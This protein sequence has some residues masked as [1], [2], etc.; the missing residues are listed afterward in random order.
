LRD[1]RLL[2][3]QVLCVFGATTVVHA[4]EVS[5]VHNQHGGVQVSFDVRVAA[6]TSAALSEGQ[7]AA[8]EFTIND[9]NN[10]PLSGLYPAAW[11]HPSSVD[12]EGSDKVC[13]DKVKTFIGGTL[14]SRAELDL[15]VYYVLTMNQDST[16]SVVDP[17]FGFGGSKLLTML[18]LNGPGYD[19]VINQNQDRLIVSV[20]STNQLA[21]IDI[22][23]WRVSSSDDQLSLDNPRD[24]FIQPDQQYLWVLDDGG[25]AVLDL[26]TI[27]L[28]QRINTKSNASEMTFSDDGAIAY[29]VT[30]Q[31]IEV[32]DLSS[33]AITRSIKHQGG[34]VS[35][36]YSTRADEL[37]LRHHTSGDIWVLDD[38]SN[39][40]DAVIP[41]T[42]GS[43]SLRFSP[44]GRWGILLNTDEDNLSIIDVAKGR[45]VQSG[46]V[47]SR[48]E[49]IAFSDN[50]AYIRHAG[51][52][53]LYMIPLDDRDLGR[54]GADIP[55]VDTPGGDTP[56]GRTDFPSGG[57]GIVQAPGSNAVLVANYG[58]K[59]VYFYK[60]GMAAPMGQFNNYGKHPRSVMAIDHSL[61]E[62][63]QKGV[64]SSYAALPKS[65]RYEAVLF[66][67]SPRVVKCFAFTIG[68]DDGSSESA[69]TRLTIQ[70]V[71]T[72]ELKARV[73]NSMR[74][75]IDGPVTANTEF[76]VDMYLASGQWQDSLSV[77]LNQDK[78]LAFDFTPPRAGLYGIRLS[79]P[80]FSTSKE[81]SYDID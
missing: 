17:L 5:G 74:Y 8:F 47:A 64:Y 62:R 78:T 36:D 59:A 20:P 57:E 24:L 31:S 67:D 49:Y 81:F 69:F 27:R 60:E 26:E 25:A 16:I 23:G 51:S 80:A 56:A 7:S 32:I 28:V 79:N 73:S 40:R 77:K 61:R 70:D 12:E 48:P 33:L 42:P 29:L 22:A 1:L 54:E 14:L 37:Y 30:E 66:M 68:A 3:A 13:L 6:G 9:A 52:S 4:A 38:Q 46:T 50:I 76:T 41:T 55:T 39:K 75:S 21:V 18:S 19:W 43:G 72:V 34:D 11:I 58:D 35:I 15:N 44:D 71:S 63:D 45:I 2:I 53:D 65:G 10:V